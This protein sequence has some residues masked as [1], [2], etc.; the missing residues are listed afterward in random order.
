MTEM[1]LEWW[2]CGREEAE[3]HGHGAVPG[4]WGKNK[5]VSARPRGAGRTRV[6]AANRGVAVQVLMQRFSMKYALVL[7]G[8][9]DLCCQH[10]VLP[11]R[12]LAGFWAEAARRLRST[13]FLFLW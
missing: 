12:A 13:T 6:V 10:H 11:G 2:L 5:V 9:W 3:E 4:F 7:S 8:E 1:P